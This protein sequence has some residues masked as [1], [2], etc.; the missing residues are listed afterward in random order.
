MLSLC[1]LQSPAVNVW[2]CLWSYVFILWLCWTWL[3]KQRRLLRN[4][5]VN[6]VLLLPAVT[7]NRANAYECKCSDIR[8][9]YSSNDRS[10]FLSDWK[11]ETT[12]WQ[13]PK[14]SES[15]FTIYSLDTKG[16]WPTDR[17]LWSGFHLA[18][19]FTM[20]GLS[21][22]KNELMSSILHSFQYSIHWL[23]ITST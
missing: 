17:Q 10:I 18:S 22:P 1:A 14:L 2:M 9:R 8:L 20:R 4:G 7:Q 23:L 21:W 13:S 3:C 16:A 19:L 5:A 12:K 6:T 15:V 11:P